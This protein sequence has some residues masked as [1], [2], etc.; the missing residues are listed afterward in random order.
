MGG[1]GVR[2]WWR[3][4]PAQNRRWLIVNAI[5]GTAVINFVVNAGLAWLGTL[6]LHKVPVWSIP[7]LQKSSTAV[8]TLGT[9]F[10]LPVTTCLLCTLAVRTEQRRRG[11]PAIDQMFVGRAARL[12]RHPLRRGVVLGAATAVVLSPLAG[13]AL[14]VTHLGD[15]TT[16]GFILY[17]A[18]LGVALGLLVTPLVALLAM[19]D[20]REAAATADGPLASAQPA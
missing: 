10:L 17:A 1:F 12:P 6:G 13:V 2:R 9:F 20:R 4:I 18:V 15:V 3:G 8:D 16:R 5:A 14:V 19:A 7:L 11:L